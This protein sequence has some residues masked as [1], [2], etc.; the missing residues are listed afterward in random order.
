MSVN[1]DAQNND[2]NT[3]YGEL[4]QIRK[5]LEKMKTDIKVSQELFKQEVLEQDG[6]NCHVRNLLDQLDGELHRWFGI[7]GIIGWI[8]PYIESFKNILGYI[9][10]VADDEPVAGENV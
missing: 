4:N 9:E 2:I 8:V 10:P 7:T 5:E 3:L 6:I 1:I